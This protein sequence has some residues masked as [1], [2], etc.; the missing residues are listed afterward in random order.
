MIAVILFVKRDW[1]NSVEII[2]AKY[3]VQYF[4]IIKQRVINDFK[5][6]GL[7]V[8]TISELEKYQACIWKKNT[9][10]TYFFQLWKTP[11]PTNSIMQY[12]S[13]QGK[14]SSGQPSNRFRDLVIGLHL[15]SV[16]S[17]SRICFYSA[18]SHKSKQTTKAFANENGTGESWSSFQ[19]SL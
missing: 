12:C 16:R 18:T 11:L 8:I 15:V 14:D 10:V 4:G 13:T 6:A 2:E 9:F 19:S 3:S 17:F 1:L 7:Q 5:G